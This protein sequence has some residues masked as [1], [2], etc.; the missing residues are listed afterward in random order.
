MRRPVHR[1]AS[2]PIR[3]TSTSAAEAA[4]RTISAFSFSPSISVCSTVHCFWTTANQADVTVQEIHVQPLGMIASMRKRSP[5]TKEVTHYPA[6]SQGTS[7]LRAILVDPIH[8]GSRQTPRN[9]TPGLPPVPIRPCRA[10]SQGTP[11]SDP[12][13][14][15]CASPRRSR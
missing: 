11:P 1:R 5:T 8:A 9:K 15:S 13:A 10:N 12:C 3:C 14:A 7:Q 4:V 6:I 2:T